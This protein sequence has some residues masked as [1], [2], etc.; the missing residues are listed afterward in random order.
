MLSRAIHRERR[1]L[2]SGTRELQ[3]LWRPQR[4]R[5]N[6]A[7]RRFGQPG[8]PKCGHHDVK[9]F[10][11]AGMARR[12]ECQLPIVQCY[13]GTEHRDCLQWFVRG[14][15]IHC[16]RRRA[17]VKENVAGWAEDNDRPVVPALDQSISS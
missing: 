15:A 1:R 13:T 11:T 17:N 4:S 2:L 5:G 14:A 10:A 16:I 3:R 9:M 8:G 6:I 12:R 7:E